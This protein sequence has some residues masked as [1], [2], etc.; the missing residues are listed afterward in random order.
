M[1]ITRLTYL[2]EVTRH[3]LHTYLPFRYPFTYEMT[4][5]V[6]SNPTTTTSIINCAQFIQFSYLP[7]PQPITPF[8]VVNSISNLRTSLLRPNV[9]AHRRLEK[10]LPAVHINANLPPE[11]LLKQKQLAINA[12]AHSTKSTYGSALLKYHTF[13]DVIALPELNR[14][15]CNTV[16]ISG[17]ITYLSGNYSKSSIVNFIAGVRAWHIVNNIPFDVDNNIINTLLRGAGRIQPIP[18]SKRPPLTMEHMEKVIL[19]LNLNNAEQL[20]VA[21]CLTT[22]FFC[23]A[24]LGEFTVPTVK[25]FNPKEH[26]TIMDV[27]F[28]H[29][30]SLNKVTAFHLPKTKTSNTGETVFWAKQNSI[31]DP[32]YLFL[33]HLQTNEPQPEEHLFSF[34]TPRG[35]IPMTRNIFLRNMQ[36]ASQKAQLPV[37]TGHSIRIG[38][39]LEYLLRGIPFEV[40]KQI[41][42][43]SSNSF[44]LYLREHGKILAPYLQKEPSVN[45]EFVEY[46]N[47]LLR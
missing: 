25:A 46:S 33:L 36:I 42:R 11:L 3:L 21:A 24:R 2:Q 41:G 27:S 6:S 39:T 34:L 15:P 14:I 45:A 9:P 5:S 28:Q 17:F 37:L 38:A 1:P 26:I 30:R 12:F 44:T 8:T 18:Q 23:C 4:S 31:V 29:D 47:I 32:Q 43:W 10:W 22:S 40:V 16:I 35:K 19:Q 20:A 7:Q 13:C